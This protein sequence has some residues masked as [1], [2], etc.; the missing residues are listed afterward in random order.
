[1]NKITFDQIEMYRQAYESDRTA[2]TMNAAMAKTELTDLAF[3]PMNAARL[4]GDFSNYF[5]T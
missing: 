2:R 4:R 5:L 3:I 1:M